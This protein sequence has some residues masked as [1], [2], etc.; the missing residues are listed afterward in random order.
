VYGLLN[1][2]SRIERDAVSTQAS[3]AAAEVLCSVES[4]LNRTE[5]KLVRYAE[6]IKQLTETNQLQESAVVDA[7]KSLKEV[8]DHNAELQLQLDKTQARILDKGE[9]LTQA[10]KEIAELKKKID[11]LEKKLAKKK[12]S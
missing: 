8:S 4:R 6:T 12:T 5:G 7:A 1:Y 9:E 11:E 10:K 2:T 3:Y